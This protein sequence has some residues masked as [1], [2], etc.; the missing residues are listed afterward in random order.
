[1]PTFLL[2]LISPPFL[3][4]SFELV[5]GTLLVTNSNSLVLRQTRN[6]PTDGKLVQKHTQCHW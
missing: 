5:V 3:I 6:D 1:M 4:P 2:F